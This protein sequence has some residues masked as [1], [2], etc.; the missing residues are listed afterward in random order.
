MLEEMGLERKKSKDVP[1][2]TSALYVGFVIDTVEQ[3]VNITPE[4]AAGLQADIAELRGCSISPHSGVDKNIIARRAL[5]S[6]ILA[7]CSG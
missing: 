4:R 3:T 5:A 1:P 6:V 2:A 7:S